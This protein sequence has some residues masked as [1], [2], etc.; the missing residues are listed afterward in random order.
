MPL[1]LVFL[2]LIA[3]PALEI[4][5]FIV[6]GGRIGVLATLALVLL[7]AVIGTLL[8][9]VQGL[10]VVARIRAETDRGRL[11]G[12]ELGDGLMIVIA[13]VLL[14]TPGFVTDTAGLVLFVPAVRA[15]IWRLIAPRISVVVATGRRRAG[16]VVDLDATEFRERPGSAP[17][18][19]LP[20]HE[21]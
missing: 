1:A 5:V 3:I 14:L 7:T 9:R 12:R 19:R 6:V 15:A 10:S 16:T 20:E 21:G 8:L 2:L 13:A 17:G 4:A 11:P 18:R